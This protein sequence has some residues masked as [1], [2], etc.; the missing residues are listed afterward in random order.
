MKTTTHPQGCSCGSPDCPQH[1]AD[2]QGVPYLPST[3]DE[4]MT[5]IEAIRSIKGV[6]VETCGRGID[7]LEV[8]KDFCETWLW[9]NDAAI[10]LDEAIVTDLMTNCEL[11]RAGAVR[12][13]AV[14][15]AY[16][17]WLESLDYVC[18]EHDAMCASPIV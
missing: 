1:V 8:A 14:D 15:L 2:L 11:D 7:L 12:Q 18:S 9:E 16:L 4:A 13:R 17:A 10:E 6:L 3:G 5:D